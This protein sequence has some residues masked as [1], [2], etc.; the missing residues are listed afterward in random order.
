[1]GCLTCPPNC[2]ESVDQSRTIMFSF[3]DSFWQSNEYVATYPPVA[4][5]VTSYIQLSTQMALC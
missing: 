2:A 5:G 4:V 3:M 1:M